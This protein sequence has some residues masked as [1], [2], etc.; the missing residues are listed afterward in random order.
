VKELLDVSVIAIDNGLPLELFYESAAIQPIPLAP[1]ILNQ[2]GEVDKISGYGGWIINITEA[3]EGI[4]IVEDEK[5]FHWPFNGY[6]KVRTD[7]V[8]QLQNLYFA[9]TGNELTITNL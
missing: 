9:L 6:L 5:G 1:E 8:H 7:F 2:V 3:G 4:R